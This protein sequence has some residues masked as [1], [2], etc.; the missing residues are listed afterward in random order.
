[1]RAG[2][3]RH[4]A[5][6]PFFSSSSVRIHDGPSDDDR[7]IIVRVMIVRRMVWRI[8]RWIIWR[9]E[10]RYRIRRGPRVRFRHRVRRRRWKHSL[11]VRHAR[12]YFARIDEAPDVPA[13]IAR[14]D[15][16]FRS[17]AVVE[18]E[19]HHVLIHQHCPECRRGA[20]ST[21]SSAGRCVSPG[22][23]IEFC[24]RVKVYRLLFRR[25]IREAPLGCGVPAKKE[26]GLLR[27]PSCPPPRIHRLNRAMILDACSVRKVECNMICC[28]IVK[29]GNG[30]PPERNLRAPPDNS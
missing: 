23:K 18:G 15:F 1:M 6:M 25:A 11:F 5:S 3:P 7:R 21:S 26:L 14:L 8:V 16:R 19:D 9:I 22:P 29:I 20:R 27:Q 24:V 30:F 10:R 28:G 4:T 17:R 2:S 13:W 12:V